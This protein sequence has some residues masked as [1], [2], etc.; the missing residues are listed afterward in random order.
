MKT[1]LCFLFCCVLLQVRAQ[2]VGAIEKLECFLDDCSFVSKF[3]NTEFGQ[4]TVPENYDTPDGRKI[5]IAYVI[6][7]TDNT[8]FKGDPVIIFA[9]GWGIPEIQD[10]ALYVNMPL[11]SERDI[12]LYDYRGTG[13]STPL[14]CE[15]LGTEAWADLMDDLSIETFYE[16][17]TRRYAECIETM[18]AAGID[19]NRYGMNNLARDAAFLAQQLPY[20]TY[21]LFGISYGTMA[22]QH[23]LR[24]A[25][26]YDITVRSVII[27]SAV[28]IGT[29]TQ[30]TMPLYYRQS[31]FALLDDCATDP[32]CN[33]AYPD[34]K[35]R[36]LRFQ[37]SLDEEPLEVG[38]D[39]GSKT[40]LNKEEFNGIL[41]QMLY[42]HRRYPTLP[43]F[44][45]SAI[46]RDGHALKKTLPTI[47]DLVI[48]SYNATGLVEYVYDHKANTAVSQLN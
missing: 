24:E 38:L 32:N 22:I 6:L 21:N 39:D 10:A 46:E 13:Y 9:G 3:P 19:Y 12:I 26:K 34:L 14:P 33:A 16:K 43:L 36:F 17:Q 35:N 40:Y 15:K 41:H 31:L 45:E 5:K 48:S 11:R 30:G 47:K 37:K 27:D 8:E 18:E 1:V 20:D 23:F 2:E 7:K 42:T 28:P 4:L 25:E 44:L 29:P